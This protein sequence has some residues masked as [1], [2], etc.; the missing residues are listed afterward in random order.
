MSNLTLPE[1][2]TD[3]VQ[4]R[5]DDYTSRPKQLA[6]WLLISRDQVKARYRAAKVELNRVN[7]RV[8][9]VSK[10]RDIWK[11]KAEFSQQELVAMKAEVERLTALIDQAL[12]KKK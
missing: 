10:S 3:D 8:A 2:E 11:A 9:D 6:R 1:Q 5:L 4:R 7:V 12:P